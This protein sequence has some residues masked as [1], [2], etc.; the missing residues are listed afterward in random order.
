MKSVQCQILPRE[1]NKLLIDIRRDFIIDDAVKE[2]GKKKFDPRKP[3]QVLY[4]YNEYIF[5]MKK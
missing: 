1:T 2:A 3:L 4:M 5:I